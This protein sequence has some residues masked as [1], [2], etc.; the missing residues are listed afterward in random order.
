MINNAKALGALVKTRRK[1]AKLSQ[2][3]LAMACGVGERFIRE[4]ERGK[5]S[6]QLEKALLVTRMLGIKIKAILPPDEA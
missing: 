3:Q 2:A 4:L 6:C 5:P 1:Q